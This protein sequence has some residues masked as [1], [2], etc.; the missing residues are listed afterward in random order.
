MIYR[1]ANT[2]HLRIN[3]TNIHVTYMISLTAENDRKPF[4]YINGIENTVF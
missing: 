4:G 3:I 1:T 2:T